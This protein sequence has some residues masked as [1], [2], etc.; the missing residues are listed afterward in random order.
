MYLSPLTSTQPN[1][2]SP[3]NSSLNLIGQVW[4]ALFVLA[5]D[6]LKVLA[7]AIRVEHPFSVCY[8]EVLPAVVHSENGELVCTS[9]ETELLSC[10]FACANKV[11]DII[12]NH[13][14]FET[15]YGG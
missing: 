3:A 15:K 13:G 14:L 11:T 1:Y 5:L 8:K 4:E 12:I 6:W 2:K 9:S 7:A 10:S